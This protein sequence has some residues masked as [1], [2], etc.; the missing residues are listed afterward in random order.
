MK[1]L[2][3]IILALIGI[4][5]F[6]GAV[7][8]W[9]AK[10]PDYHWRFAMSDK[11][12]GLAFAMPGKGMIFSPTHSQIHQLRNSFISIYNKYVE[13]D[14]IARANNVVDIQRKIEVSIPYMECRA[15]INNADMDVMARHYTVT[16]KVNKNGK[17][18]VEW[19]AFLYKTVYILF[20]IDYQLVGQC[21]TRFY[22]PEELLAIINC[23]SQEKINE[24]FAKDT[25]KQS[26]FE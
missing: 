14:S 8:T 22:S 6:C 10:T 5:Q 12:R 16:W 24:E 3:L 1:R 23:L 19:D 2:L 11:D 26:L 25:Q 7:V 21:T 20:Q 13:W 15:K 9:E 18:S 17:S 4:Y